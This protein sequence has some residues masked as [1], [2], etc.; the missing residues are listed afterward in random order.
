MNA[1]RITLAA[2][3]AVSLILLSIEP[4]GAHDRK[5]AGALNLVFGWATEP[6]FSG[7]LNGI[8]VS[9]AD[10]KG[11][12][13]KAEGG[14]AVEVSFGNERITL[15]LERVANRPNEF[16]ASLVP[17]RAGTYAFRVTGRINNQAIDVTSTCGTSTFHCVEDNTAIQFPV[18]DPSVGQLAERIDRALPRASDAGAAAT[19]A[20]TLALIALA[21]S[22]AGVLIAATTFVTAKRNA[23]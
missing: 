6:A 12:L 8:V 5:T 13:A 21:L 4:A 22:I 10:A 2:I 17:T 18:K 3:V 23:K 15:P 1:P 19:S 14:L 16:H 9:L 11:P 7:S 20:R